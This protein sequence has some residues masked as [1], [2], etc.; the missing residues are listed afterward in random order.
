VRVAILGCGPAGLIAAYAAE[1][2]GHR[3]VVYSTKR[4]STIF[5]AQYLHEPILGISDP[6]AEMEIN[7]TKIGTREGYAENVY[8]NRDAPVSWDKFHNGWDAGWD[9]KKVYE[10]LWHRFEPRIVDVV[11]SK[12]TV[13]HIMA[14]FDRTFST[15]PIKMLCDVWGHSFTS[16]SI[17]VVHGPARGENMMVYNGLAPNGIPSWYRYSLINNYQSWE[18]AERHT[19]QPQWVASNLTVSEGIKPLHTDCDCHPE[20]VRFGRFG[21][22]NKNVFTH[23]SYQEVLDALQ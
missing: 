19:P 17:W 5:G 4:K 6:N 9:L 3:V 7:I 15:I 2:A 18:Y 20:I 23:H 14:M 16:A 11:I 13:E 10:N 22:W 12:R 1:E 8:G 21:R